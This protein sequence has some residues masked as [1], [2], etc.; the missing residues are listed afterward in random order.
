[1]SSKATG[2]TL[3]GALTGGFHWAFWVSGV[4]A[5]AAV[6]ATSL[7]VRRA[8]LAQGTAASVTVS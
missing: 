8:E 7:L 1:M 5:L 3:I 4:I 2:M 6:P